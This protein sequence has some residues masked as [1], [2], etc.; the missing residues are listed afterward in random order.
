MVFY[1][2]YA[3]SMLQLRQILLIRLIL[4]TAEVEFNSISCSNCLN[5]IQYFETATW[6]RLHAERINQPK[7]IQWILLGGPS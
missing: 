5:N 3:A 6:K 2:F 4:Q 1:V 7:L